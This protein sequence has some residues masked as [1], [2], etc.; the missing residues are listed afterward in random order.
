MSTYN[1]NYLSRMS[2]ITNNIGESYASY[3]I[4]I[5]TIDIKRW[6]AIDS[7]SRVN[8]Q[9]KQKKKRKFT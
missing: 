9:G 5:L 8:K 7:P 1:G 6:I 4:T 3:M 2:N